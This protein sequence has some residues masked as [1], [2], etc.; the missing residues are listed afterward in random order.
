[1]NGSAAGFAQIGYH[2][3]SGGNINILFTSGN[4]NMQEGPS[5]PDYVQIGNGSLNGDVSGNITGDILVQN[6]L[7]GSS[8]AL[9][10]NLN[11][12][13]GQPWLGN[14]AGSGF[15]ET[16]NV[17]ILVPNED[18]NNNN[19]DYIKPIIEQDLA[20]GNVI[21]GQT[22]KGNQ[23]GN[24]ILYGDTAIY[25]SP[26]NFT[27][28]DSSSIYL[29]GSLQNTGAGTIT[30][31]AGWNGSTLGAA[32][33]TTPNAY[34]LNGN[35][36]IIGAKDPKG[37]VV[38]GNIVLG[39]AG[40]TTILANGLVLDAINGSVLVGSAGS[41]TG[42][43]NVMTGSGGVTLAGGSGN[44]DFAQIGNQ[45]PLPTNPPGGTISIST[46]GPVTLTGGAG[47]GA[48]A[49]VGDNS[50]SATS[51]SGYNNVAQVSVTS[52]NNALVTGSGA[53]SYALIGNGDDQA[54]VVTPPPPSNPPPASPG[55]IQTQVANDPQTIGFVASQNAA[56]SAL[57]ND[58]ANINV[59]TVVLVVNPPT[60]NPGATTVTASVSSSSS[61]P[62]ATLTGQGGQNNEPASASD[63]ATTTIAS[64]LNGSSKPPISH[65]LIPGVLSQITQASATK[66]VHGIPPADQDF[67]SW[68]NEAFWQ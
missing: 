29:G 8:G 30:L 54:Q 50:G 32:L 43:V 63:T 14:F 48:Y 58:S 23:S 57:S 55:T 1:M 9:N 6:T 10:L 67:S 34:G 35:T 15:S 28:L 45:G 5:L 7:V 36:V 44:G 65:P 51:S 64:S 59:N 66:N 18:E 53:G 11:G 39:G 26:F 13:P 19:A 21:Y 3:A 27:L 20:G 31:V 24:D 12:A 68:G 60:T 22:Q 33:T 25:S 56:T 41:L 46:S 42:G 17:T 4:I 62:I 16:G 61:N 2:G 37:D 38:T 47:T 49:Q 52:S 40:G